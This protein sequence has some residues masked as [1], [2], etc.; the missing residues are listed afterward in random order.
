MG[1]N[2]G[3]VVT[4]QVLDLNG[5]TAVEDVGQVLIHHLAISPLSVPS[6]MF[7]VGGGSGHTAEMPRYTFLWKNYHQ[8]CKVLK[9]MKGRRV[10][11]RGKI[12]L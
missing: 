9:P 4:D 7:Q 10:G 6:C 12:K 11:K 2:R 8:N 3:A 1:K 5:L